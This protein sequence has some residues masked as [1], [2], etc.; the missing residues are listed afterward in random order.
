MVEPLYGDVFDHHSVVYEFDKGVRVYA[1]C[2]TTAGC[3]DENSSLI[4]GAK[5]KASL[6][7]CRIWGETNWRWQGQ[8][9]PYQIEHDKLFAGIRSG[10]P[11]NC[12]DYMA[13]STMIGVMGQISCY[14]GKEVTWE[15]V[16]AS[17]YFYPPKPEDCHDGME[18]PTKPGAERQLP[19]AR[20]GPDQDD[21][22]GENAVNHRWTQMN[23]D[24]KMTG[25]SAGGAGRCWPAAGCARLPQPRPP[26]ATEKAR[27]LL[28]TGVDYPGHHWRETA[29]VLA[30]ALRKDPRLEVFTVE[31][32]GFLDSAAINKYDL[33]P[34]ALPELAAAG[35]GRTGAGEPA[36]VRG[37]RQRRGAGAFCLR[38]M[39][40]RVAGV[41]ARSPAGRG[42]GRGRACASMI[43]YGPFRVELVQAGPS[44]RA[45]HDGL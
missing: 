25:G 28:V 4:S 12:G 18:P 31:D 13:R 17:D 44:D 26:P 8:C 5:G 1:F 2:R 19:G 33:H 16:M 40:R 10:N 45:R 29:P 36:P 14:T 15:Q 22:S 42:P 24:R 3:Y 7:N 34:A 41:R 43:P 23:T 32:P 39:V 21:L 35:A 30:E 27:I 9:D 20:A 38:R 11:I 6:L 37:R